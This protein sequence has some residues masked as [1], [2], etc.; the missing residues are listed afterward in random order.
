MS[1]AEA[2]TA[3]EEKPRVKEDDAEEK[4]KSEEA[5][6]S[7]GESG[8]D[9]DDDANV[10]SEDESGS[11]DDASDDDE[12]DD[13]EEEEED[14][15]EE[16]EDEKPAKPKKPAAAS[17]DDEDGEVKAEPAGDDDG[18]GSDD[19]EIMTAAKA[20][21]QKAAKKKEKEKKRSRNQFVD[22]VADDDD[23]D[24]A[25]KRK[26]KK[27]KKSG[28]DGRPGGNM[29]IDD[30]ADVEDDDEEEDDE[31]DDIDED[32]GEEEREAV[33]REAEQRVHA[34]YENL[35]RMERMENEEEL[36]AALKER[37]A[38]HRAAADYGDVGIGTEVDQQ[39]LHPTVRDPKLWLVTV[40]QGKEREVVVCLMQK[41]INLHRSGKGAMAIK[42]AVVQDHLK[43]Y[44]YVEA[45]REDHVKKALA[46]LRHVYHSKPIKLVPIAEMVESVTVT[47]KKVSNIKMGS[48]VRMRGGA[49]KGD[50]AKIVDV[51][52]ADN[53]CTVKLV[54]R[55]DY[56]HLQAKEEGTH[57]GRK[58]ANLRP[59]AR[60]F[61]EAMSAKY[62]LPLERSRHDRRMRANVDVL[63]G[64]HKLMDGYYV[65]T[66]SLASCKLAD[67]P[68]LDELQRFS[69][70]EE[71]TEAKTSDGG[72]AN[73]AANLE[74]LASSLEGAAKREQN[75]LPG[76]HVI[77]VDGDLVNLTGVVVHDNAD[78][79]VK[80]TPTHDDIH[81]D[82]DVD[83]QTLRKYFKV[84]SHVRCVHGVHDGE[85]GLVVKVE[86]QVTTVFSDVKQEEFLVFSQ[87]LADSKEVTRRVESI[88]VFTI[89]DLVQLE[90][91]AVGMIVRVEKDAAMVMMASSTADR[92]DVRPVKLHDMRRKLM[93][94]RVTASD[95]GMETIENGSMVRIVDGPGKG[96]RLTVKHI[97]RGTLWGKVRGDVAD[98]GGI[99]AVKARSCRV[100]GSK[101]KDGGNDA[102]RAG[103]FAAAPQSPGAALL[104]SP[105]ARQQ[106]MQMQ[107]APR[108]GR[109]GGG[110]VGRRD[111]SLVGT[112]IKVSAGVYKGYKGKVVDATETTVRVELQA[113]AR[114]VTVQRNQIVMPSAAPPWGGAAAAP[115]AYQPAAPATAPTPA[116]TP[117]REYARTP[118]Y[119][120][121]IGSVTPLRD[122]GA[123]GRTPLR[124]SAWNPAT[125]HHDGGVG[126]G[127]WDDDAPSTASA[128]A[129]SSDPD[130]GYAG[131]FVTKAV[132]SLPDG[133][134]GVVRARKNGA[135][136]VAIGTTK[137]LP[138]GVVT[139]DALTSASAME[140]V[141]ES[142][143][144]LAPAQK[145][146]N[147]VVVTSGEEQPRGATA[148][149]ISVDEGECVMKMDGTKEAA[150]MPA[151]AIARVWV[152]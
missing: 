64:Q 97:N 67:A 105:A 34:R 122:D 72:R 48:W 98:F 5:G 107:D 83:K 70:G 143:L 30:M 52:F 56:A 106:P 148:V 144:T 91:S 10:G 79:S 131:V 92:P 37:Y 22:D 50:L 84:G 82:I 71:A 76:D 28:K 120:D 49:Y 9:D 87:D 27:G 81:E 138:N 86:G 42:S 51:N 108:A 18:D 147:V 125:P 142:V 33:M 60:L 8:D 19:G 89:H 85:S 99:V 25:R 12:D 11:D 39:A 88:G 1:D 55:F 117:M 93:D 41:A 74:A 127:G 151:T 103:G 46:G 61:T 152:E 141:P 75:F 43:S 111:N 35:E 26:K 15:D 73:A 135:V 44:V 104:R 29:F 124:D 119:G 149:V 58:K 40:K 133:R 45:E 114:T 16:D 17:D 101:S 21:A 77:C 128:P 2:E 65:K 96:M 62:N 150:M 80:I 4:K 90:S 126:G 130:A 123:G 136:V 78:G 132:V 3:A 57:Q 139:L 24:G 68:A 31:G 102:N 94:R 146:D 129:P 140:T 110:P 23:D 137:T 14:E 13:E 69:T 100:D 7:G 66:I 63:C 54:P 53:Q 134:Q 145:K 95:A 109:F 113:Q 38:A 112:T 20:K 116:R 32:L 121:G 6:E 59:P 47:K 36:E 115:A 118:A